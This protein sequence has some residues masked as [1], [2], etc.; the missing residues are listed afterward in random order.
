M[1]GWVRKHK[2]K[3]FEDGAAH[4]A[5]T[6]AVREVRGEINDF[7]A[8]RAGNIRVKQSLSSQSSL[9]RVMDDLAVKAADEP[10][11]VVARLVQNAIKI[12]PVRNE[13]VAGM[14]LMFGLGGLGA[15]AAFMPFVQ[16]MILTAGIAYGG[17]RAIMSPTTSG[18]LERSLSLPISQLSERQIQQ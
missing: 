17:R 9:L 10:G 5:M 6:T 18:G 15:A 12:I 4:N 14:S 8:A 16:T 2:P 11:S 7:I 1:D 3:A 13:L